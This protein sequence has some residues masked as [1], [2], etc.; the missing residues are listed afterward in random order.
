VGADTF[1]VTRGLVSNFA[2]GDFGGCIA[3]E[4]TEPFIEDASPVNAGQCLAF[5][6]R[7]ASAVCGLGSLGRSSDGIE[8]MN[9]NPAACPP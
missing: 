6:V 8:R 9:S 3:P 1:Q 7:P 4:I 5:L 2:S